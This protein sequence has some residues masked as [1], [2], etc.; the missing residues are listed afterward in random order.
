MLQTGYNIMTSRSSHT[1][2]FEALYGGKEQ[3][4]QPSEPTTKLFYYTRYAISTKPT[5]SSQ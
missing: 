4:A 2:W 1:F 3:R 5:H